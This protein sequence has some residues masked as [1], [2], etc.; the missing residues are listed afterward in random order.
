M[1]WMLSPASQGV[2][3]LANFKRQA[4]LIILVGLVRSE[5]SCLCIAFGFFGRSIQYSNYYE[6]TFKASP[7]TTDSVLMHL[8]NIF[9]IMKSLQ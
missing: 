1:K 5:L 7:I 4:K 6:I 3:L 9:C 2:R 8:I